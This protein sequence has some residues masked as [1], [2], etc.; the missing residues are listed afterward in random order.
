MAEPTSALAVANPLAGVASSIAGGVFSAFGQRSANRANERIARENRKFQERMSSTAHQRETK[1][2]EAAGLNRILGISGKGSSTPGGAMSTH[3]NVGAAAAE[4]VAKGATSALQVKQQALLDAQTQATLAQAGLADAQ[5][6]GLDAQLPRKAI[7]G[8]TI[9][10]ARGQWDKFKEAIK[11]GLQGR[12]NIYG[13]YKKPRTNKP[14]VIDVPGDRSSAAKRKKRY[15][16]YL[17]RKR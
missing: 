12:G 15:N 11:T 4:G 1:D 3:G 9:T 8:D 13:P 17:R 5:T 6:A 16:E 7:I 10:S 2:L 14:L